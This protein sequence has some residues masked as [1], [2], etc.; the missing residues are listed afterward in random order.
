[1][2]R[3]G[4][5]VFVVSLA[6]A[7]LPA[8]AAAAPVPAQ[9]DAGVA[10]G[11]A[12]PAPEGSAAAPKAEFVYGPIQAKDPEVRV[13]IKKLYRDQHDLQVATQAQLD[14]LVSA[15][16]NE[17]D[18]DFR[19]QIQKDMIAAKKA[20]QIKSVEIGLEIARLNED[21][22]RVADYEKALDQLLHPEKYMP[23]VDPSKGMERAQ[24]MGL[25]K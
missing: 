7:A 5:K 19:F 2:L 22:A 16:Q 8:L 1:M 17:A 14:E 23:A 3:P 6:F 10:P 9:S 21:A 13:Q 18:P 12:V 20:M 24:A 25:E 15:L 11:E 4:L